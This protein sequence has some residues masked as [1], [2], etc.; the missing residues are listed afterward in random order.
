MQ[1][2]MQPKAL[3]S[4]LARHASSSAQQ[5]RLTQSGRSASTGV[6]WLIGGELAKGS[7]F[8]LLGAR[9]TLST[10]IEVKSDEC[11]MVPSSSSKIQRLWFI[12]R[13][14]RKEATGFLVSNG[15]ACAE[16]PSMV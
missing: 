10:H 11:Q 4:P 3:Q 13:S 5:C 1:S 12:S 8:C 2:F 9:S 14:D 15:I 6:H 7:P 16:L